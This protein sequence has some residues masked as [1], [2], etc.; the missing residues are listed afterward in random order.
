MQLQVNCT[1]DLDTL[2]CI[3]ELKDDLASHELKCFP[4]ARHSLDIPQLM[5]RLTCKEL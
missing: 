4:M 3:D 5:R 1:A 2:R